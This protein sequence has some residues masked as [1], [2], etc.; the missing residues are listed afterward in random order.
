MKRYLFIFPVLVIMVACSPRQRYER[1]LNHELETGIRHDSLFQGL[2]LGMSARDFYVHCWNLN[3]QGLVR[4]GPENQTVA[5]QTRDELRFP[6]TMEYYPLFVHDTIAEMP[7]KFSYNGWTPWNRKLSSDKLQADVLR[8]FK[9]MYGRG[10]IKVVHPKWG[11]A[12][13]KVDGNRRIAIF[14]EDQI[15]VW[16][17]FTDLTRSKDLQLPGVP[18]QNQNKK[19]QNKETE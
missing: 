16:A 11:T 1:M 17:V 7:V 4:Q 8:W 14:K 10:F 15:H 2:Y 13:V 5:Y 18:E 9:K 6:A 12:W 19:V 3:R